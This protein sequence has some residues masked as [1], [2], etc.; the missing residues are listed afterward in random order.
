MPP[1]F[2]R[3]W[4]NCGYDRIASVCR[5]T[6]LE[7][8]AR[9]E[10]RNGTARSAMRR[11][12]LSRAIIFSP[13]DCIAAAHSRTAKCRNEYRAEIKGGGPE[14]T[15]SNQRTKRAETMAFP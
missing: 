7:Q 11:E 12:S 5:V 8:A 3:G 9:S 15:T 4:A 10:S 14:N 13:F 6:P 1:A 2:L